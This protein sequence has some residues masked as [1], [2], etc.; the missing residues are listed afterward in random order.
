M[1]ERIRVLY[2]APQIQRRVRAL[3]ARITRDY[4]GKDLVLVGILKGS[5]VFL[6]DLAR[7]IKLPVTCEF[8]RVSSYDTGTTSSGVVRL[9]FDL[10]NP[11]RGRHVLLVE[12]I[13][14]TGLTLQF[15]IKHLRL[16]RPASLRICTF[17]H[18]PD[19][20]KVKLDLDYIGF[21][22]PNAFVIGY[23]LDYA[24]KY[25]NLPQVGVLENPD[26]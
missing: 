7:A 15:L 8:L 24:G 21:S 4:R 16:S 20:T 5:F 17:L 9:D 1:A 23:G 10:T 2:T 6:A 18:K 12:D 26:S 22:I 13:V 3:G 19:R 14:D 25:R 11:I